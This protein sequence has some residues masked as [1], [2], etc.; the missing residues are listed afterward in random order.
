MIYHHAF[1]QAYPLPLDIAN[2][3]Q[4]PWYRVTAVPDVRYQNPMSTR[5]P[6]EK[7]A[8]SK[9]FAPGYALSH[10]L[11]SE[12]DIDE[13][14]ADL[15]DWMDIY[16]VDQRPMELDKFITYTTS[17]NVGSVFFSESFGFIKAVRLSPSVLSSDL[18]AQIRELMKRL[19]QYRVATS[20]APYA[21]T[22]P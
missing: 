22:L 4:A 1:L 3:I 21:T 11:K 18:S 8:L 2:D 9:H 13:N 6:K 16:A 14:V 17:D 10:V 5:D 15:L 19:W 12:T 7:I 20:A